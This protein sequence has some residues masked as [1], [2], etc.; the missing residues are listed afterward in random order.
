MNFEKLA[1]LIDQTEDLFGIPNCDCSVYFHHEEVFRRQHGYV[2]LEKT[3]PASEDDLYFLYSASKVSLVV[4]AMQLVERGILSLSDPV[5]KYLPEFGR[6][7]IRVNGQIVPCER[8]ATIED[9]L[10]MRAGLDYSNMIPGRRPDI[11][12]LV[13]EKP[14]IS[15]QELIRAY[16]RTPLLFQ[17]G[18]RFLYSMCHDVCAAVIEIATGRR[19]ADYVKEEIASP[20]GMKEFA[21]HKEEVD[22]DRLV[23]QYQYDPACNYSLDHLQYVPVE[24]DSNPAVF[25]PGYDCGGAGII[26]RVSDYVL[27]ADALANDGVGANG[28]RILTRESIDDMRTNRLTT[29]VLYRDHRKMWNYGYGYGLGVRT[30]VNPALSK[31]PVGEFGWDGM[32]GAFFLSDVENN[33][34]IFFLMSIRGIDDIKAA[35]HNKLRDFTYEALEEELRR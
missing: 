34:A 18:S 9:L 6:M 27:L 33:V 1:V 11:E 21:L 19:Y 7:G 4:A 13:A 26:T 17:P 5:S 25:G 31:S 2:D 8:E 22:T 32:G 3:K 24:K 12:A 23:Q 20:L 16:I 15:T 30:L 29:D 14:D 28:Q 10:S 35:V